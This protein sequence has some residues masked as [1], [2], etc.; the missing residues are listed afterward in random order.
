MAWSPKTLPVVAPKVMEFS[1][2]GT[3]HKVP[4]SSLYPHKVQWGAGVH[5]DGSGGEALLAPE[6]ALPVIA[7]GKDSEVQ[8]FKFFYQIRQIV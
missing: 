1:T 3:D 2:S 4:P 6:V 7:V 8:L 5:L